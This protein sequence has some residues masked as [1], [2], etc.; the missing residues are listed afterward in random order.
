M[1]N[2]ES[3]A[4][5][6]CMRTACFVCDVSPWVAKF[7]QGLN[8]RRRARVY[9]MSL[10]AICSLP[11]N[12]NLLLSHFLFCLVTEAKLRVPSRGS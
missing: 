1:G 3:N 10:E 11:F 6:A 2:L 4:V 12:Q 9:T 8:T 7:L 5:H